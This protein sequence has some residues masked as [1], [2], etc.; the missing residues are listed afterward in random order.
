MATKLKFFSS[1][2]N[3]KYYQA[4]KASNTAQ[5]VI[6]FRVMLEGGLGFRD[7]RSCY[8][9]QDFLLAPAKLNLIVRTLW[10]KVWCKMILFIKI[11]IKVYTF[12]SIVTLCL[13]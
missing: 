1:Q 10:F 9:A 12:T 3:W 13:K 7:I 6:G 2:H 4:T 8:P 5:A 11:S